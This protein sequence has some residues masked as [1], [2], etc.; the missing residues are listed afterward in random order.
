MRALRVLIVEDDAMVAQ[1]NRKEVESLE[2]FEVVGIARNADEAR[3][4]LGKHEVDLVLLDVYMP[5]ESG[6]DLLRSL[7]R[8]GYKADVILVTADDS[9]ADVEEA[10]RLG[11]VDYLV[12]PFELGRL[13][14]ALARYA[15]RAER[16]RSSRSVA[17]RDID[18]LILAED[19]QAPDRRGIDRRTAER[20]LEAL[21]GLGAPASAD[22]VARSMGISRVTAKKYLDYL[23]EQGL[24]QSSIQYK[25]TGR[26][27][28]LYRAT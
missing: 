23:E 2:G 8:W 13:R 9:S 28:T 25:G 15:R 14:T 21:R 22:E 26:P 4:M 24:A 7:R 16:L 6:L 18:E 27:I 10:L 20:V 1:M 5:G 19:E 17:Q 11:A 12:K 3:R